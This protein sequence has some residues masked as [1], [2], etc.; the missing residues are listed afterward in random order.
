LV[1]GL[2]FGVCSFKFVDKLWF[3]FM[4]CGLRFMV[5]GSR[6]MGCGLCIALICF[7]F[8][9]FCFIVRK[10]DGAAGARACVLPIGATAVSRNAACRELGVGGWGLGFGVWGLGSEIFMI[11]AGCAI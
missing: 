11:H 7:C 8:L 4:V 3:V 1:W 10:F 9:L 2:W 6:S 5:Y